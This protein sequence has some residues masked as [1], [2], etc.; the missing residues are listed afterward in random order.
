MIPTD[1]YKV[2]LLLMAVELGMHA[3]LRLPP[4]D[5]QNMRVHCQVSLPVDPVREGQVLSSEPFQYFYLVGLG[6]QR[7][8]DKRMNHQY[9]GIKIS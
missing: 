9:S 4:S 6:T 1:I 8:K 5:R 3:F 2:S 7:H